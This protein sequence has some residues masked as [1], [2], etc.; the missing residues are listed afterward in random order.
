MDR[1]GAT[2]IDIIQNT[3]NKKTLAIFFPETRRVGPPKL[4]NEVGR[5]VQF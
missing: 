3:L 2:A 4:R 5:K 1:R